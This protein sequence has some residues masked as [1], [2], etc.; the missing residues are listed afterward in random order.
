MGRNAAQMSLLT[1]DAGY[2]VEPLFARYSGGVYL[3]WNFWCNVS[4]PVQQQFCRDALARLP[5]TLVE[6]GRERDYRYAFYR[7]ERPA[8]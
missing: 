7:L 1:S 3:H 4:D 6:E 2:A 8:H 5:H